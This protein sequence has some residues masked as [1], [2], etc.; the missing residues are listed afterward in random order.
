M[1]KISVT[2]N[3]CDL[4]DRDLKQMCQLGVDCVDFGKGSSFPGVREQG[5]P[6][7]DRLLQLRRRVRSFGLEMNRVTLPDFTERFMNNLP[8]SEK[9]LDNSAQAVKVFGAAGLPIVRQRFAGDTS[10]VLTAGYK[11]VQRGGAVARGESLGLLRQKPEIPGLEER[12]RFWSRFT[13]AFR[14]LVPVAEE[15][16][17]KLTVHPSDT[18]N[19]GTPFGGL[20]FHRIIDAF[21]NANVGFVYCVGTRAEEGGSSLV[22]DE[23]D[24]YGRKGKIFLVHLRNVRGS[25]PTAGAFEEALLDDG[26]MNMFRI[27]LA[28]R[29]VGYGGCINPDHITQLEGDSVDLDLNWAHSGIGWKHSSIGWGYSIGY[30]RALLAALA[31]FEGRRF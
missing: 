6:D 1:M 3:T 26:D 21:P 7:L 18:P 15:S 9:E 13:E 14:T 22:L 16:N 24:H 8:G 10:P 2:V 31:E 12:E 17:V 23:I 11:A 27:L 25:L 30:V 20:G 28:L 4:T 5:Y 19:H 29:K